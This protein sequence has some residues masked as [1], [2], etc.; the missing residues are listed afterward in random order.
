MLV[1][2][3]LHVLATGVWSYVVATWDDDEVHIYVDG[4]DVVDKITV[5]L[6]PNSQTTTIAENYPFRSSDGDVVVGTQIPGYSWRFNG[7]MSDIKIY[8]RF[9]EESEVLENYGE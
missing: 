6:N 3:T 5:D 9:M 8:N 4:V 7:M 1:V 2:Q